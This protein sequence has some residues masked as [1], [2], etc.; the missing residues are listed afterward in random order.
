MWT[1][2]PKI[3]SIIERR[4]SIR[5]KAF[6]EACYVVLCLALALPK[7][8]YR[9]VYTTISYSDY[10]P[11]GLFDGRFLGKQRDGPITTLGS[12]WNIEQNTAW[13]CPEK[14]IFKARHIRVLPCPG[15]EYPRVARVALAYMVECARERRTYPFYGVILSIKMV[16]LVKI[17]RQIVRVSGPF[18]LAGDETAFDAERE[19]SG[20]AALVAFHELAEL[21]R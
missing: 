14:L 9:S 11:E 5:D 6:R 18:P 19:V 8:G 2:S 10:T 21:D 12:P 16:I 3:L 15:I 1:R 7:D 13:L 20:F 4:V 17:E